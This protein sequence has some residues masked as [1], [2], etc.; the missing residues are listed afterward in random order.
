MIETY[1]ED[2]KHREGGLIIDGKKASTKDILFVQYSRF[3]IEEPNLLVLTLDGLALLSEKKVADLPSELSPLFYKTGLERE[4]F[5]VL[6]QLPPSKSL[7]KQAKFNISFE[8]ELWKR[9][10]SISEFKESFLQSTAHTNSNVKPAEPNPDV[11]F[12]KEDFEFNVSCENLEI[13]MGHILA[14]ICPI[15]EVL[16]DNTLSMLEAKA[17]GRMLVAYFDFPNEVAV[18]C[19]QYLI[20]FVQFLKD[21]GVNAE[22]DLRHEAGQLL[23]SVKPDSPEAALEQIR[24]ALNIY[25]QLP[26]NPNIGMMMPTGDIRTQQLEAQV[27]FLQGNFRLAYATMQ[28]QETTIQQRQDTIRDQASTIN[29]LQQLLSGQVLS[30]ALRPAPAKQNEDEKAEFFDGAIALTKVEKYGVEISLAK[31][32]N[33]LRVSLAARRIQPPQKLLIAPEPEDEQDDSV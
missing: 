33:K 10:W 1:F 12:I 8:T 32:V 13:E 19:E 30:E 2:G 9:P 3:L 22:A 27:Q 29:T 14:N 15:I 31:I 16:V 28:Q 17:R 7:K 18:A 24:E 23:F 4:G 21:L 5:N 11:I 25:L 6:I 26:A 20:Y